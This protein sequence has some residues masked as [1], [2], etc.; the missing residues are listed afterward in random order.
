MPKIVVMSRSCEM[1]CNMWEH[2]NLVTCYNRGFQFC[3][4]VAS[5]EIW[6]HPPWEIKINTNIVF[7]WVLTGVSLLLHHFNIHPVIPTRAKSSLMTKVTRLCCTVLDIPTKL[8]TEALKIRLFAG[9]QQLLI[10]LT[11]LYSSLVATFF[12][13]SYLPCPWLVLTTWVGIHV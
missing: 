7:F 3:N 11:K 4:I 9:S 1:C 10:M 2:Y 6:T 8:R 13:C 5:G 12:H